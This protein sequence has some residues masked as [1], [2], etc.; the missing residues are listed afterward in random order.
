MQ[1]NSWL[2]LQVSAQHWENGLAIGVWQHVDGYYAEPS[3]R[4]VKTNNDSCI[5]SITAFGENLFENS[6]SRVLHPRTG[7]DAT[8]GVSTGAYSMHLELHNYHTITH[9]AITRD[10]I[11]HY[12][13]A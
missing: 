7:S 8:S 13:V 12:A 3:G 1:L 11:T 4:Q 9:Y 2:V 6:D 10:T 5:K